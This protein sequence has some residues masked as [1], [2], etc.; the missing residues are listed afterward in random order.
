MSCLMYV[1]LGVNVFLFGIAIAAVRLGAI[2]DEDHLWFTDE[3][4]ARGEDEELNAEL[5]AEDRER[6]LTAAT[7]E[8]G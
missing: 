2:S 5:E 6:L 3:E 4:R 8:H 1:L 7:R